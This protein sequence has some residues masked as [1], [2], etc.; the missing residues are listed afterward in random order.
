MSSKSFSNAHSQLLVDVSYSIRWG[1]RE[2]SVRLV[3]SP[4]GLKPTVDLGAF[5]A[6]FGYAQGRL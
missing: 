3:K 2:E 6:P 1:L 5:S 4:Q